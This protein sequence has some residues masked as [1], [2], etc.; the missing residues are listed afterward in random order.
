[1]LTILDARQQKAMRVEGSVT[2]N[3]APLSKATRRRIGFVMQARWL[4]GREPWAVQQCLLASPASYL[5]LQ[6]PAIPLLH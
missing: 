1:M 3:G 5:V 6:P 4:E 2:F